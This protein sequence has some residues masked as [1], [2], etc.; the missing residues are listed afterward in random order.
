MAQS[1]VYLNGFVEP[2]VHQ[3][4]PNNNQG[5]IKVQDLLLR[6]DNAFSPLDFADPAPS[7][8]H[9]ASQSLPRDDSGPAL[10]V[11]DI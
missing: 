11:Q 4:Q 5:S 9:G 10:G 3:V 8:D 6:G 1:T 2:I 7:D